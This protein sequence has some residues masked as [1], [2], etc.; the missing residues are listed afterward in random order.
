MNKV[1]KYIGGDKNQN[2][3]GDV[4][5]IRLDSIKNIVFKPFKKELKVALGEVTGHSHR[6][7]TKTPEKLSWGQ[8]ENGYYL[9]IED[10]AKASLVHEEH[11][12][13]ELDGGIYFFG[14]QWEYDPLEQ[15]RK[16]M[17]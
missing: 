8:D 4:S 15:F 14:S 9:K 11:E 7:I 5:V 12:T 17:D 6:V 2:Y 1:K 13:H 16:V 10:G 3:Q